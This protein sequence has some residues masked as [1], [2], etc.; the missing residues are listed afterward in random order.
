MEWAFTTDGSGQVTLTY[1][2]AAGGAADVVSGDIALNGFMLA[3]E[4]I[5]EPA[6]ATLGLVALASLMLRRRKS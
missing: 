3:T 5:P 4:P 6:T 1:E 2:R